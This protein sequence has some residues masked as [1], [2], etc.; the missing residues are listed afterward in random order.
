MKTNVWQQFRCVPTGTA[1]AISKRIQQKL[2]NFHLSWYSLCCSSIQ[3]F[4]WSLE[5]AT[6]CTLFKSITAKCWSSYDSSWDS[7]ICSWSIIIN[8]TEYALWH[9]SGRVCTTSLNH[10]WKLLST[11][12]WPSN[13]TGIVLEKQTSDWHWHQRLLEVKGWATGAL[14]NQRPVSAL[15]APPMRELYQHHTNGPDY[16][17]SNGNLVLKGLKPLWQW[18]HSSIGTV[19]RKTSFHNNTVQKKF[20]QNWPLKAKYI[21]NRD[22]KTAMLV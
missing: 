21:K 3:F 12:A 6:A 16:C 19:T 18:I 10:H 15:R 4:T 20:Q 7:E 17:S 1:Q 13:W 9:C 22:R 2:E 5:R 8:V 14:T 11:I